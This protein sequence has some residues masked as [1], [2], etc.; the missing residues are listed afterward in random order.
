M[1]IPDDRDVAFVVCK[2][3]GDGGDPD[4]DQ[5]PFRDRGAGKACR[6]MFMRHELVTTL[7]SCSRAIPDILTRRKQVIVR[8]IPGPS[9]KAGGLP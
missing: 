1:R 6:A 4:E 9:H 2:G 8:R 7:S 3:A 5:K